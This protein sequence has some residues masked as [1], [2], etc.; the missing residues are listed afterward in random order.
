MPDTRFTR[1]R[2]AGTQKLPAPPGCGEFCR[3]DQ[4]LGAGAGGA[5]G[6]GLFGAPGAGLL[7]V[8]DAEPPSTFDVQIRTSCMPSL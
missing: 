2:F 1:A 8:P 6:A 7:I 3:P 5:P 4:A